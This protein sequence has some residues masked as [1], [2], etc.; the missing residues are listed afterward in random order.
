MDYA[1][2]DT[3]ND[4][5]LSGLAVYLV[6]EGLM[7]ADTASEALAIS[8][9]RNIS[10]T[11]H[12]VRSGILGSDRILACCVKHFGLPVLELKHY[13]AVYSHENMISPELIYR[14]RVIP[15]YRDEHNLHIGI[16]DPTDQAIVA[17]IRFHT[18]L[19]IH[20]T[21]VAED[22]LDKII[23]VIRRSSMLGL[24]LETMLAK[25]ATVEEPCVEIE[26]EQNDE[27]VIEF[28]DRMLQDAVEK[29][30]SDIHIEPYEQFCRIRFRH[31]GLLS[32]A[33]QVPRH[34][35]T[36]LF[37]RLKI[38]ANLNIAERRMPQD[39]RFQLQKEKRM[40]VRMNIS[41]TLYGEKIVLRLLNTMHIHHDTRSLGMTTEQ[42][43]LFIEEINQPQGLILVTGPTGSGKT[44]TLYSALHY[45]NQIEKNI[46]TIEDPVEIEVS[47][48]NQ[49]SINPVIGL[50]FAAILRSF[51]RQDP[52]IIMIGEIR[53]V[54]TANIAVQAA[55]TGHLV[56][57]S[58]HAN[59]AVETIVRL[60]SMGIAAHHLSGSLSLI[61]AQ[62]L[63]R[64]L[65][66]LCKQ[67]ALTCPGTYRPVGCARCREGYQGRTAI[68]ELLPVN[69][70]LAELIISGA[71]VRQ[72]LAVV[73]EQ[74][75]MLLAD[76]GQAKIRSGVTS[77][78]ELR[79]VLGT[80]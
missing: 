73:R 22:E 51:L 3:A 56:L 47:G 17:A 49:V 28:V 41:P 24:Q 36:R 12:L 8:A 15:V 31:D 34:L 63:V 5:R 11:S 58:I 37:A 38:M 7:D 61:I 70:M 52:D 72:L 53:D 4:F 29:Q 20:L 44:V 23:N 40:H 54:N 18:G 2:H 13:E 27:P 55:Q 1:M 19:R 6:Y 43:A 71:S 16:A 30:V 66:Q 74:G 79:R 76:A 67:P 42:L 57:S 9:Q 69:D 26:Y 68:F 46:S 14:Y 35:A 64:T 78:E 39:G 32:E 80:R 50:D 60:N 48:I 62:R 59:S 77:E 33:A 75:Y 25:I 65:C 10:L 45:L 21:L